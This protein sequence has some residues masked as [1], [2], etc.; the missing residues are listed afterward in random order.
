MGMLPKTHDPKDPLSKSNLG[1]LIASGKPNDM[2]AAAGI[3]MQAV[4]RWWPAARSDR[5]GMRLAICSS[6]L[7]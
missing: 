6:F 2:D 5:C 1:K 4:H 7:G 3:M